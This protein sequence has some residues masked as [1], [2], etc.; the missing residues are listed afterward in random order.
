MS[1]TCGSQGKNGKCVNNFVLK[2]LKEDECNIK[3]NIREVVSQI[4]DEL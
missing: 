4:E 2:T 3:G 1:L